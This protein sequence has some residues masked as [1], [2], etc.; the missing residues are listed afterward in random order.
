MCSGLVGETE[1]SA[2]SRAS[3]GI[4]R[5]V[6]REFWKNRCGGWRGEGRA[7]ADTLVLFVEYITNSCEHLPF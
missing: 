3:L 2:A 5:K 4:W 1:F 7:I 6:T